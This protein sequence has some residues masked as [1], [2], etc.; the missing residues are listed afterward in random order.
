MR[1]KRLRY[2]PVPGMV[3]LMKKGRRHHWWNEPPTWAWVVM[4]VGTLALVVGVPLADRRDAVAVGGAPERVTASP[5]PAPL[6]PIPL[7]KHARVLIFGD[8]WTAGYSA[9]DP[10]ANG[11]A[12]LVAAHYGWKATIDGVGGTGY[13]NPGPH[14]EGTY[15]ARIAKLAGPAPALILLQG[16]L[17]D[18]FLPNVSHLEVAALDTIAAL[19]RRFPGVPIV[20]FGPA[21]ISVPIN[22]QYRY[23]DSALA[24]AAASA[25]LHY[26]SPVQEQWVTA[27]NIGTVI[28]P[29]TNHPGTDGHAYLAGKVEGDLSRV[30]RAG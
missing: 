2:D 12:Y 10:K 18:A 21:N 23:A 16:G 9:T 25:R 4:I 15:G 26:I 24:S 17:N 1:V 6:A 11:Y 22:G 3:R 19:Q 20:V 29:K 7:S 5:S 28:D 13:L 14:Q 30:L 27:D 8:S